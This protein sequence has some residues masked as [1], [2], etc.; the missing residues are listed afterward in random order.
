MLLS[1]SVERP[2][3]PHACIVGALLALLKPPR[4]GER[5]SNVL[6]SR[7]P[8]LLV[9]LRKK[10]QCAASPYLPKTPSFLLM[11][12]CWAIDKMLLVNQ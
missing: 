2:S 1:Q 6:S 4:W 12:H 8:G 9:N 7:R 10:T 11:N 5:R 3:H